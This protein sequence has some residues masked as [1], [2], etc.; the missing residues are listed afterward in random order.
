MCLESSVFWLGETNI[1]REDC[2]TVLRNISILCYIYI[3][4]LPI[5][6][7][8][9]LHQ[10]WETGRQKLKTVIIKKLWACKMIAYIQYTDLCF[11]KPCP[12][13][14]GMP[15]NIRYGRILVVFNSRWNMIKFLRWCFFICT[16]IT[17]FD[18]ATNILW[19]IHLSVQISL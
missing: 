8:I 13:L 10:I 17:Y 16:C 5:C 15:E 1:N 12:F 6:L 7:T 11:A 2:M 18:T 9:H 4:F 19:T 3:S 14:E